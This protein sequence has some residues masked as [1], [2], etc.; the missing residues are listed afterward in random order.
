MASA[1]GPDGLV[2]TRAFMRQSLAGRNH[3]SNVCR[4]RIRIIVQFEVQLFSLSMGVILTAAV[5]QAEGRISRADRRR[6]AGSC[7]ARSLTRLKCAGFRDDASR[8]L[9]V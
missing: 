2:R 5:F 4:K 9:K 8:R 7:H 3:V 6:V 1:S